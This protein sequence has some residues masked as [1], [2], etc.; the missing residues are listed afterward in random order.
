MNDLMFHFHKECFLLLLQF[1]CSVAGKVE[2]KVAKFYH[3][4]AKTGNTVSPD[5]HKLNNRF[6]TLIASSFYLR[7][8]II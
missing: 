3:K 4:V 7:H 8:L 6:A 1:S 5:F 2:Q